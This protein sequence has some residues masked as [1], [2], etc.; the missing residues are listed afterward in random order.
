LP[1]G[2][3]VFNGE[4]KVNSKNFPRFILIVGALLL[5]GCVTIP[6]DALQLSPENLQLRQLQTRR[7]DTDEKTLLSAAAALLQDLGFQVDETTREIGVIS[8]S[9]ERDATNPGQIVTSLLIA[10]LTGV[11]IPVDRNQHIRASVV[12][13]PL[14]ID[15]GDRSNCQTAIR[16]TFQRTVFNHQ[17]QVSR[18]ECIIDKD[19]YQE[20]FDKLSKSLFLGAHDI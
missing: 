6:P 12:T 7:Y 9:K 17:K 2:S 18:R 10:A 1:T 13:H 19:I 11:A 15:D 4:R 14:I 16:A 20:F 8:A 5:S 3:R